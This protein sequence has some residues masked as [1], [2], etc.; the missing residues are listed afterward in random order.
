ME[1]EIVE[2]NCR[3]FDYVIAIAW[4]LSLLLVVDKGKNP[5][6]AT[7][8][9]NKGAIFLAFLL[10]CVVVTVVSVI[11]SLIPV[12]GIILVF[13]LAL[14]T[15]FISIGMEKYIYK[16]F[17]ADVQQAGVKPEGPYGG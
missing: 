15:V 11:F 6:E 13:A 7:S 16:A 4:I 9:S 1:G 14:L 5:A 12:T 17:C 2:K 10:L 8:L 3:A